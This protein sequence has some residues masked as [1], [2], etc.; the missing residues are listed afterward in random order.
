MSLTDTEKRTLRAL[1]YKLS[2]LAEADIEAKSKEKWIRHNT[3]KPGRPLFL[4]DQMP[5]NELDFEPPC[6]EDKYWRV[7]ENWMRKTIWRKTK[8]KTD[9]VVD[10]YIVL[11]AIYDSTPCGIPTKSKVVMLDPKNDVVSQHME[12]QINEPEDIEK[13]QI[14]IITPNPVRSAEI[15]ELADELFHDI[16]PW[17]FAH[18]SL[19]LGIWDSISFCM[20]V[21]NA[22]IEILDRPEMMH[23]LM[24]RYVKAYMTRIEQLNKYKLYLPGSTLTHCSHN[25][26]PDD[27]LDGD[28][29]TQNGWAFGMAQLF[30]SV[31]PAVTKEFEVD[32]VKELFKQFK[33]IYYGCCDR[34]DDRMEIVCTLPNVRKL[35][36]SP[37][38]NRDIFAEKL[39]KSII[40]SNKPNPAFLA[41]DVFDED[42]V[43][44]DLRHTIDAARKNGK[45]LEMILKDISTVKYKPENL[46]R[47]CEIAME[48]AER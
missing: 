27:D 35:S 21:E 12:C 4:A 17:R 22:Y 10:P 5:W 25:Y 2:E 31:S 28:A 9:L 18:G 40:M 38:S 48:E 20:G 24:Q 30:T 6:I 44:A 32:Y 16:M 36:C 14:P 19:H 29:V 43:R 34:L 7:V 42:K 13:I 1:A 33:Y 8:L 37:W 23:A 39:P 11:P 3:L 47:Y 41:D 26:M 45:Q 15:A 46:V